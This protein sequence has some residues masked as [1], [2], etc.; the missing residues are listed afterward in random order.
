MNPPTTDCAPTQSE[1]PP[2]PFR[3][4]PWIDPSV[5]HHRCQCP[6]CRSRVSGARW[7]VP[8]RTGLVIIGGIVL[9]GVSVLI[10]EGMQVVD[11][12][13]L[14][15]A[16]ILLAVLATAANL[17]LSPTRKD[18]QS[19]QI[20]HRPPASTLLRVV[21]LA[22]AML[23]CLVWGYLAVLFIPVVPLAMIMVLYAGLGLCGLCPFGAL[24]ISVI[25]AVRGTRAVRRRLALGWTVALVALPVALPP[26]AM[27][28]VAMYQHHQRQVVKLQLERIADAAPFSTERMRLVSA[29]AGK[30]SL[31]LRRYANSNDRAERQRLAQAYLR[32][33]DERIDLQRPMPYRRGYHGVI[34]PWW[35]L[36][37]GRPFPTN[38]W[39]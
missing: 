26:V 9:P 6:T 13:H 12:G 27:A 19:G 16:A 11:L 3:T 36:D 15:H 30:E 1:S 38:I 7:S 25:Q 8:V 37:D 34:R 35:F 17:I 5:E 18:P 20:T 14:G 31:L 24:A 23:S 33:T 28:A 4:S 32:L 2:H 22:G 21:L 29:M 10:N 39:R